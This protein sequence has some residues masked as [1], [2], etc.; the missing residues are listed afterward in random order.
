MNIMDSSKIMVS[1]NYVLTNIK[2]IESSF[3]EMSLTDE[4]Y[5][6]ILSIISPDG[7]D[8][9]DVSKLE[10]IMPLKIY[11]DTYDD[12]LNYIVQENQRGHRTMAMMV[13][14]YIQAKTKEQCESIAKIV[15][16]A[17]ENK[18]QKLKNIDKEISIQHLDSYY[19]KDRNEY[20]SDY[21][22]R[23][24]ININTLT[25]GLIALKLN[26]FDKFTDNQKEYYELLMKED[27]ADSKQLDDTRSDGNYV[28]TGVSFSSYKTI[29]EYLVLGMIIGCFAVTCWIVICYVMDNR[30]QSE[31]EVNYY[32][33]PILKSFYFEEKKDLFSGISRKIRGVEITQEEKEKKILIKDLSIMK[34]MNQIKKIYIFQTSDKEKD[35]QIIDYINSSFSDGT[36]EFGEPLSNADD[37]QRLAETEGVIL[38]IHLRDTA[39]NSIREAKDICNRYGRKLLGTVLVGSC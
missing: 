38:M 36:I 19:L 7:N 13:T 27:G 12:S 21:E 25:N 32:G 14:V 16:R 11:C 33:I 26:Y 28:K 22:K 37:L 20:L 34:N 23:H 39:R 15:G 1:K 17:L 4:Y 35:R 24:M 29:I 10:D 3:T 2:G 6:E 30:I 31:N 9:K 8:R 18:C 5:D